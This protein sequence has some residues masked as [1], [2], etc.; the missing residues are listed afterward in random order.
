[1]KY[2]LQGTEFNSHQSHWERSHD[3]QRDQIRLQL[4]VP[5]QTGNEQHVAEPAHTGGNSKQVP[6]AAASRSPCRKPG[7]RLL[8]FTKYVI[9]YFSVL[10]PSLIIAASRNSLDVVFI[11]NSNNI[12]QIPSHQRAG[13]YV[14]WYVFSGIAEIHFLLPKSQT[15]LSNRQ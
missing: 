13:I 9:S 11:L 12:S 10:S 3:H 7:Q 4:R 15:L 6:Q 2:F 1:M 8:R 14:F 5:R